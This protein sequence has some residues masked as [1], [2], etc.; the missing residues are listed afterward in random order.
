VFACVWVCGHVVSSDCVYY[1]VGF[2]AEA[3][4]GVCV[5]VWV[6]ALLLMCMCVA[7]LVHLCV[8]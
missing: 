5:S 6:S 3:P 7:M 8:L 4:C 1:G 2:V